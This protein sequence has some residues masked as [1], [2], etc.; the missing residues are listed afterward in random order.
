MPVFITPPGE[1]V[2]VHDPDEGKPESATLP[3]AI[4]QVG[5]VIIPTTGAVGFAF[6]LIVQVALAA[7]QGGPFGLL[8][9]TVI[10]IVF[11]RS[12]LAGVYV[13]ENG[14]VLAE[15]GVTEPLPFPVIVTSVALPPNVFPAIVIIVNPQVLTVLLLRVTVG[16]LT[17]CPKA[18]KEI[19]TK[20]VI[21]RKTLVIFEIIR[22]IQYT[23]IL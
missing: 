4:R 22:F 11:P 23:T 3:V 18:S 8:V 7:E 2:R 6:T 1:R 20:K 14:E 19:I 13:N 21:Y 10:V 15:A 9:V 17:H 16:G 5:C 12:P